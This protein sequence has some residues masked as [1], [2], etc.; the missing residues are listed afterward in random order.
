MKI[1]N[2]K[3]YNNNVKDIKQIQVIV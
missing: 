3:Q 1:I 2:V